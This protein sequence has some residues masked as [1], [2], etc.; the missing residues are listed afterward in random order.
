M[1]ERADFVIVLNHFFDGPALLGE[2]A[3]G[4]RLNALAATGATARFTP[5]LV[6]IAHDASVDAAGGDFPHMGTFQFGADS[7]ATCT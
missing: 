7:D 6:K 4:A 2:S 3:S 1:H 5:L